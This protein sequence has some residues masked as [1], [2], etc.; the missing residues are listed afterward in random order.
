MVRAA[1]S[2]ICPST[3]M[4]HSP[5]AKVASTPADSQKQRHPGHEH[6]REAGDRPDSAQ[7]YLLEG[8]EGG[9]AGYQQDHAGEQEGQHQGAELKAQIDPGLPVA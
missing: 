9:S 4:F 8:L 2:T 5:A 7:R 1:P 3:P 6:V